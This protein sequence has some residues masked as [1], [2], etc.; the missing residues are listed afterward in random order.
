MKKQPYLAPDP[1]TRV[2]YAV[3]LLLGKPEFEQEQ[4]YF[5]ERGHLHNRAFHG[6]GTVSGLRVWLDRDLVVVS[7]GLAVDRLGRLLPVQT[8]QCGS[9]STWLAEQPPAPAPGGGPGAQPEVQSVYVTLSYGEEERDPVFVPAPAGHS[10]GVTN[11]R[12]AET[13]VIRF[14]AAPPPDPS[15]AAHRRFHALLSRVR[16]ADEI[17]ATTPERMAELVRALAHGP[18]PAHEPLFVHPEQAAAVFAAAFR[19]FATDLAPALIQPAPD[20]FTERSAALL[21]ARIDYI[22]HPDG[23]I[24][25]LAVADQDRPMLLPTGLMQEYLLRALAGGAPHTASVLWPAPGEALAGGDLAGFFPAPA[26]ARLQGRPVSPA[27]PPDGAVLTWSEAAGQWQPQL[28]TRPSAAAAAPPVQPFVT[29]TKVSGSA[30]GALDLWFHLPTDITALI[31]PFE[32]SVFAEPA[33]AVSPGGEHGAGFTLPVLRVEPRGF[34]RMEVL[35]DPSATQYP[36]LRLE[37]RLSTGRRQGGR[38][39]AAILAESGVSW[40]GY[41]GDARIITYFRQPEQQSI[42][43]VVAAGVIEDGKVIRGRGLR[44]AEKDPG[45]YL[46]TFPGFHKGEFYLVNGAPLV[47]RRDYQRSIEVIHHHDEDGVLVRVS[48]Y[49]TGFVVEISRFL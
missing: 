13:P 35:L 40:L 39:L 22:R 2:R 44:V 9:L 47:D 43:E 29:V 11:S 23:R 19:V 12:V 41:D 6:Y 30:R 8:E 28:P 10:E 31:E 15:T 5:R 37:F 33:V 48:G 36:H 4:G 32:L 27:A 42:T 14:A 18:A 34:N 16:V 26:V 24:A 1:Y 7:P 38:R 25:E 17:A 46:L 45:L 49:D 3:G 21:L 20:D